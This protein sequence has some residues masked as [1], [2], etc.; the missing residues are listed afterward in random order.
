MSLDTRT[1][2]QNLRSNGASPLGAGDPTYTGFITFLSNGSRGEYIL[3]EF[4][5]D[6]AGVGVF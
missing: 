4:V 3:I 1:Y 6:V 2:H 5:N